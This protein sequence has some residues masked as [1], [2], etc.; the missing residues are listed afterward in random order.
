[1]GITV[2][3][4]DG[5]IHDLDWLRKKYGNFLIKEAPPGPAY[6]IVALHEKL[7]AASTTVV[8]VSHAGD[9]PLSDISIAWY[10]PDA[11]H[12]PNCGP[13]NGVLA[14]MLP[15]RCVFGTTNGN[16][17]VGFGMGGGAYYWPD[18]GQIGPHA[19]WVYGT[20]VQSDVILG[21]G[22]VGAT[23]HNHFDIEFAWVEEE[24]DEGP[25]GVTFYGKDDRQTSYS[26]ILRHFGTQDVHQP[27]DADVSLLALDW[28]E[29]EVARLSVRVLD[30]VAMPMK[31]VKVAVAP[32]D[33]SGPGFVAMTNDYGV[34]TFDINGGLFS[35]T[36]PG[37]GHFVIGLPDY[38]GDVYN[39][40]GWVL[41]SNP[42][43]WLD[44]V[45]ISAVDNPEPE[46][47]H[48]LDDVI[49]KLDEILAK[50]DRVLG[51]P[52]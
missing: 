15:N 41:G 33:V 46:P 40:A 43:R 8:T 37:Q 16:G 13:A 10:W 35:Y 36:V 44:P 18:K 31:G 51:I 24:E 14:N 32:R 23:N 49:N 45:F 4:H 47:E 3:G 29:G 26:N 9:R 5:L 22:M 1:M 11:P 12:D 7:D 42:K 21:L 2:Y 50:L 52:E 48:T 27:E 20:D 6:R 34:A 39:S 25:E 30:N 38:H 28:A 19:V 17:D